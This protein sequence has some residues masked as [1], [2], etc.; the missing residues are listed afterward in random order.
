MIEKKY[1]VFVSS[2]YL[3]LTEERKAVIWTLLN[4][5]FIV[6]GMEFFPGYSGT[7][8]EYINKLI[9]ECDYVV[10]ILAG[11]Y[12]SINN[13]GIGFTE[14]EYKYALKEKKTVIPF[15]VSNI[16]KLPKNK[17]EVDIVLKKKLDDFRKEVENNKL[18]K[19][20]K[21]K[22]ELAKVVSTTM[23]H[24][25]QNYP[26]PGWVKAE[27]N[28]NT[29]IR[30]SALKVYE[31]QVPT[32]FIFHK[33]FLDSLSNSK[34]FYFRGVSGK[35]CASRIKLSHFNNVDINLTIILPN[36]ENKNHSTFKAVLPR[37][38]KN[39]RK[40]TNT[41]QNNSKELD[42]M[43]EDI[44]MSIVNL[45]ATRLY[46]KK[47]EIIFQ[48][49]DSNSRIELFEEDVYVAFYGSEINDDT[50]SPNIVKYS[51]Q[52]VYYNLFYQEIRNEVIHATEENKIV[53]ENNY[54]DQNLIDDFKRLN[55]KKLDQKTIGGY[56]ANYKQ[57]D[58]L[59]HE[60]SKSKKN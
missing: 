57:V 22:S 36:P 35:R 14:L 58:N 25:I 19:L 53:I 42:L 9:D 52:S 37:R 29:I 56:L 40:D 55:L 16:E 6:E 33:D 7:K 39:K 11:K 8:E 41:S 17:T 48:Q 24:V 26:S 1:Q 15:L 20:W 27:N 60:K 12:G 49:F 4:Q 44:Y 31:A 30:Y 5:G 50:H 18:A 47:C 54:D 10:L 59:F 45:W 51:K 23:A 34:N 46:Y 38:I 21:N 13:K 32:N 28:H 43:S 2:T 3:D